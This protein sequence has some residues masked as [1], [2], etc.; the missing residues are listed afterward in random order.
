MKYNVTF[1]TAYQWVPHILH[2][3]ARHVPQDRMVELEEAAQNYTEDDLLSRPV[4]ALHPPLS[5]AKESVQ[6]AM[7]RFRFV[8]GQIG[9]DG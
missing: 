6:H 2:E 3:S 1:T 4:G 7:D 8:A 9:L 5:A